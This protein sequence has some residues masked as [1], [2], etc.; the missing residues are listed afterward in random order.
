[1][2]SPPAPAEVTSACAEFPGAHAHALAI[3]VSRGE[4]WLMEVTGA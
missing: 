1:M 2:L 3:K 4:T